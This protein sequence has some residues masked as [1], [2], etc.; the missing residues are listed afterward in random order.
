[1]SW[2]AA[3]AEAETRWTVEDLCRSSPE[4]KTLRGQ[5]I[6]LELQFSADGGA[7]ERVIRAFK[8]FGYAAEDLGDEGVQVAVPDT[9]FDADDIWHHEERTAQIALANGYR[10]DGW[11][12]FEP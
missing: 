8:M 11:G 1:M 2:D 12:F 9:G 5:P 7:P 4:L 10:P 6:T 3:H